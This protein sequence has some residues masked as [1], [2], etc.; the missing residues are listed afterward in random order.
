[1]YY[2]LNIIDRSDLSDL[3]AVLSDHIIVLAKLKWRANLDTLVNFL[4]NILARFETE[5]LE[6]GSTH[7]LFLMPLLTGGKWIAA[8]HC[9][10]F[11]IRNKTCMVCGVIDNCITD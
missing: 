9:H 2:L 1:M 5:S 8:I 7:H 3:M 4:V 10:E 6:K 11:V